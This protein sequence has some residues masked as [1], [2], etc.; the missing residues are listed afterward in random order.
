MCFVHL[1]SSAVTIFGGLTNIT[2]TCSPITGLI[3]TKGPNPGQPLVTL[4]FLEWL[5]FMITG[6][7]CFREV[8][9]LMLMPR[10]NF[11]FY[12]EVS[13]S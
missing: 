3:L 13:V 2:F 6:N 12:Q 11:A 7:W 1:P 8:S 9:D 5:W 10:A 4:G